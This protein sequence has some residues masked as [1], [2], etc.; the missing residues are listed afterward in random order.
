MKTT[1]YDRTGKNFAYDERTLIS[2]KV[3][4]AK[5]KEDKRFYPYMA[6]KT[7]DS[8]TM[9]RTDGAVECTC[10]TLLIFMDEDNFYGLF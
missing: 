7:G 5:N 8:F 4:I 3:Y 9:W 6:L 1:G 10:P 2:K